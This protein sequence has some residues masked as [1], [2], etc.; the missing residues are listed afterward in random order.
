MFGLSMGEV[1]ILGVLALVVI[2]PKQLPEFARAVARVMLEVRRAMD[3]LAAEIRIQATTHVDSE[4]SEIKSEQQAP[5]PA[6]PE[7]A[8]D[9][10]HLSKKVNEEEV[11]NEQ[12]ES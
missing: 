11:K 9:V 12:S 10:G 3:H 4:K 2:G 1:V 8:I 6:P 7:G 5:A